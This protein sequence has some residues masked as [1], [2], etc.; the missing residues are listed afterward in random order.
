MK[1]FTKFKQSHKKTSTSS[2]TVSLFKRMAALPGLTNIN[3]FVNPQTNK[4]LLVH[5]LPS[6]IHWYP[7]TNGAI[8]LSLQAQIYCYYPTF[9]A[10]NV[11]IT[12]IGDK[13]SLERTFL[14]QK[15]DGQSAST[16]LFIVVS[17]NCGE[18]IS[19]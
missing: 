7:F 13:A 2:P 17:S 4:H 8:T 6:N 11:L 16:G 9:P 18:A 5:D 14:H 12:Q 19:L 15:M 1:I 3:L 10:G